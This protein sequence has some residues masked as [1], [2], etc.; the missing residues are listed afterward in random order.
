MR[1][2]P[3]RP[4]DPVPGGEQGEVRRWITKDQTTLQ[5]CDVFEV[6]RRRC[7]RPVQSGDEAPAEHDFF[8]MRCADFVN[9]V[10]L[11]DDDRIV[12]VE[13]WRAGTD[14]VTLEVPGGLVD[15]GE[16]AA[17]A[18][19]RELREETGYEAEHWQP[20]GVCLPNPAIQSNRCSTYLATGARRLASTRFDSTEHCRLVVMPFADALAMVRTGDISHALV[21]TALHFELARRLGSHVPGQV[22]GQ[23]PGV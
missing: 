7:A 4:T 17:Q 10:A 22:P 5:D 1:Q 14:G 18:A 8:F 2:A 20:L 12:L 16:D 3:D 21:I 15:A 13:Q 19:R 6:I 11:T 23:V 9:V